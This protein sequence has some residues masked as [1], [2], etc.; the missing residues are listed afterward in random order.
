MYKVKSLTLFVIMAA[1]TALIISAGFVY[2]QPVFAQVDPTPIVPTPGTESTTITVP[3]TIQPTVAVLPESLGRISWGAVIAGVVLALV[4]QLT[5]NLLGIAIGT[6]QLDPHDPDAPSAKTLTT[7]T[8]FWV[9]LSMIISLV[10]GGWVAARFA[11]IPGSTDG[12]LHGL[13]VWGLVTLITLLLVSS[14]VGRLLSGVNVLIQRSLDLVGQVTGT[15]A[16]GAVNVAQGAANVTGGVVRGAANVA[17]DVAQRAAHAT[18]D[19]VNAGANAVRNEVDDHPEVK[20]ALQNQTTTRATIEE[21]VRKLIGEAGIPQQQVQQVEA[22]VAN[23]KNQ[24]QGAAQ[25]AIH[26]AQHGDL[27]QARNTLV[28][29]VQSV[30][31]QGMNTAQNVSVD[32]ENVINLITSRTQ[33]SRAEAERTLNQWESRFQQA[34]QQT[35]EARQQVNGQMNQV[36]QQVNAQVNQ[37]RQQAEE[38][39]AK[40]VEKVEEVRADA[41]ATAREAADQARKALGAVALALFAALVVGAIAAGIGGAIG[42][43]EELPTAQIDTTA[44]ISPNS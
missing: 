43:P 40:V 41:E 30:L 25:E 17:G 37:V 44:L 12:M 27:E 3:E 13:M 33:M 31:E 14:T 26:Q 2:T 9:G 38:V 39:Q 23:A 20:R 4:L 6:T 35:D 19:A 28:T 11:G 34:R 32:R 42:A 22:T 8:V 18:E 16:H 10:I 36:K 21:E 29:A 1:I 15:L 24:V 7:T 5:L